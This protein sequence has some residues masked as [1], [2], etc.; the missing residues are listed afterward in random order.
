MSSSNTVTMLRA[1]EQVGAT[2][3][4]LSGFFQAPAENFHSTE[5]VEIDI[6]RS[7]EDVAIVIED[8]STGYR[9]NS[10]DL[11]T[12]KK[13]K[14]PVYK[15]AVS[16]NASD[17]LKRLP[18]D[19]PFENVSARAKITASMMRKMPKVEKKIMRAMELQ[20]SQVLQTGVLTLTDINGVALYTL[21]FQPKTAHF[22]TA[23]TAWNA[24]GAD[25]R[26]DLASLA[27]VI[28]NNGLSDPDILIM[29]EDAF[30]AF[31]GNSDVQ[32]VFETRR[33][34]QGMISPF[35]QRGDGGQFRGEVD[36]ANYK[37]NVWTY[38]NRYKDP[39]TGNKVQFVDPGKV[40]MLSS[41]SRF[42]A[43][44][45]SIPNIGREL[46]INTVSILPELPPRFSDSGAG[47]DLFTNVW[48]TPDGENLFGGVGS[49]PLMI[50]T[51]IDTY[52]CLDTG[53]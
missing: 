17:L 6:E 27:N 1:Y 19:N 43:T 4:F 35:E 36:I 46:G 28:R 33:I 42:D 49:R 10:D 32:A 2:L 12:N 20:A 50:P 47:R 24:G 15:E 51:A 34:D 45:G 30:G 8:L 9:Y 40:I 37:F 25:P 22:P 14:P 11:Y 52:G 5:E 39:Q 7:D 38:G 53:V 48:I 31:I 16:L 26:G 44:F 13:F 3:M 41:S 29:G 18:G 23:G 21:D